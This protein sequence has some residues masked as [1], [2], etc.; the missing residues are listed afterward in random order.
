MYPFSFFFLLFPCIGRTLLTSILLALFPFITAVFM[1]WQACTGY[2]F[3]FLLFLCV[4]YLVD[5]A[6]SSS[7]SLLVSWRD[8]FL[9]GKCGGKQG[10]PVQARRLGDKILISVRGRFYHT[11][12]VSFVPAQ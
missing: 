8:R 6:S 11:I 2:P 1:A 9:W 7:R 10:L 4:L 5:V 3:L 12:Y